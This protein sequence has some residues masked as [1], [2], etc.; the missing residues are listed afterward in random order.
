MSLSEEFV[1][2]SIIMPGP[3]VVIVVSSLSRPLVSPT[4][5]WLTFLSLPTLLRFT[6]S[7]IIPVPPVSRIVLVPSVL[8]GPFRWLKF[9]VQLMS[10]RLSLVRYLRKE[11]IPTEPMVSEFVFRQWGARVKLLTIVI[12][13]FPVRGSRLPLPPSSMTSRVVVW[14]VSVRRVLVLNPLGV[15]LIVVPAANISLSSLLSWVL[16][17]VLAT[18]L[19]RIV[20][21]SL[22][23]VLL[24]G[25]GTLSA[26]LPPMLRVRLPSLF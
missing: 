9:P 15:V 24:L 2:S 19:A 20:P 7:S 3:V 10:P 4:L 8:L 23:T 18:P 12:P 14:C 17:L 13:L 6:Y 16:M 11:L 26:E 1:S 25:V 5:V 22:W 21:T